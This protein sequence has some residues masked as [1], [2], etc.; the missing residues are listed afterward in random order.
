MNQSFLK[1]IFHRHSGTAER[2][3]R[4]IPEATETRQEKGRCMEMG[5]CC[6]LY[7]QRF[8]EYYSVEKDDTVMTFDMEEYFLATAK[9]APFNA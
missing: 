7:P 4:T 5:E 9:E 8:K 1:K 6:S 3:N 2:Q